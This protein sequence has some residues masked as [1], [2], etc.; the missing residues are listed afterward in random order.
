MLDLQ[1]LLGVYVTMPSNRS[2]ARSYRRSSCLAL[3]NFLDHLLDGLIWVHALSFYR[4]CLTHH[5]TPAPMVA[6]RPNELVRVNVGLT[7]AKL[8]EHPFYYYFVRSIL[9]LRKLRDW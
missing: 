6:H 7:L 4:G 5:R 8:C 2:K 9:G 1:E 3:K